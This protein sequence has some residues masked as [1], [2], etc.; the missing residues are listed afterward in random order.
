MKN[1]TRTLLPL[2]A[3]GLTLSAC[4]QQA[5]AAENV[6]R[7]PAPAQFANEGSGLRTAVFAGGCFWGVEAVFSH[8]KGVKSAVA[9]YH[10]G[11]AATATYDKTN[12]GVTGHAEA[13]RITY[14]PTIVRYDQLLRIF[15]SVIADP[16]LHNRQG[17]DTGSQYR[18]ALVPLN[19]EQRKVAAS[20]LKQMEASGTWN[21]P[22]VTKVER[23]RKFYKGEEYHQDFALKN[24]NHG[25][26]RR[27]DKPKIAALKRLYP[28]HYRSNFVRN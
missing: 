12:S 5:L 21:R 16:T 28:N 13:V 26:I 9:G 18:A 19:G 3:L 7:A 23:Y 24:P 14:D 27:W 11:N 2:A 20:Y 6:V 1:F 22:I 15:F 4:Q 17:P 10:G 8:V 25:Y